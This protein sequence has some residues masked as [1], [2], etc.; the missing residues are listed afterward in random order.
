M[1][2]F[3]FVA[4]SLSPEKLKDKV[5]IKTW[6]RSTTILPYFLSKKFEV[7]NGQKFISLLITEPMIG[8]KLGEFVRTKKRGKDARLK[9]NK[10]R[11]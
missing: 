9:L 6:S 7:Y 3:Q 11:K 2:P 1:K 4:T 5:K 8:H 10:K